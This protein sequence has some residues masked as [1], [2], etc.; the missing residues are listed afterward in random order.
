MALTQ[1]KKIRLLAISKHKEKILESLQN[2]SDIEIIEENHE[3]Q[4][5]L[6]KK[7]REKLESTERKRA[8][9]EFAIKTLEKF[10]KKKLFQNPIE[11]SV[12]EAREI[13]ESTDFSGIIQKC[14]IFED[15]TQKAQNEIE[16]ITQ[17][18][19]NLTPYQNLP[20]KLDELYGTEETLTRVGEIKTIQVPNL[21]EKLNNLS[22]HIAFEIISEDNTNSYLYIIFEKNISK[23]IQ[24]ISSELKFIEIDLPKNQGLLKEH[25]HDLKKDL[26]ES[27]RSI[28][29]F[30]KNIKK[31]L[32]ELTKLKIAHDATVWEIE[33]LS[34]NKKIE[35]TAYSFCITAWVPK[36]SIDKLEEIIAQTTNEYTLEVLQ[37]EEGEI[38][39][40]SIKNSKFMEPFEAVT[41]TYGLP[42]HNELDPT[43][44]LAFFFILYFALCL[45]DAGYGILML[46]AL[47]LALKFMKFP[48]EMKKLVSVLLYGGI[49]TIILGTLFGGWFGLSPDQVPALFTYTAENG[50]KLFLLQKINPITNPLAVLIL[51]FALG[52]V[53]ITIGTYIKFIH[54][55]KNIDKKSALL[56]NLPWSF[57]LTGLGFFILSLTKV[58]SPE[59]SVIGKYWVFAGLL[60]L[61]L[62][63]GREKKSLIGKA[64]SGILSL[65]GLVNYLSDVLSYSRLLALGLATAIIGMA[66]NTIA[67]LLKDMIPY[68]G[69]VLMVIVFVVGHILNLLINALGA[70]IHAGRLQ[71]VEFFG[72]FMEGGGKEFKP[73]QKKTKYI[74]LTK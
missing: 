1:I 68:F 74:Y 60:F 43:P 61:V 66:V 29:D 59:L 25:I 7:T 23:D 57:F 40:V 62:T 22:K 52:F 33:K 16:S 73:L 39:P 70:F 46:I 10:E 30:T 41:K 13:S 3:F 58:I 18:I 8:E 11:I 34:S 64:F 65:Y 27:K 69:Y 47:S 35:K 71:F 2:L 36:S 51:S 19:K 26:K 20:I 32:K 72:K 4:N 24:Q 53:Q 38:P 12:E 15:K 6:T 50:E 67:L 48:K 54:T 37:L 56:D 17:K 28:K 5:A 42:L 63:Q 45:T 55:Y 49:V 9:I 14:K 44:Y 31:E 21:T